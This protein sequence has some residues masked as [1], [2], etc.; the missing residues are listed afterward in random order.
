[1]LHLDTIK[2]IYLEFALG[3]R[4]TEKF[5][6]FNFISNLKFLRISKICNF[7]F[8]DCENCIFQMWRLIRNVTVGGVGEGAGEEEGSLGEV[9]KN[10]TEI[11]ANNLTEE[12]NKGWRLLKEGEEQ[13]KTFEQGGY[14]NSDHNGTVTNK[15]AGIEYTGN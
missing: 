13:F 14:N 6:L 8:K 4:M 7:L 15:V 5:E 1:M 10:A 12:F 2:L 9:A 3:S 11:V